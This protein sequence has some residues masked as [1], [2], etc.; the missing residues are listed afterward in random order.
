MKPDDKYKVIHFSWKD[1]F[2]DE[3]PIDVNEGL[4]GTRYFT[5]AYNLRL[6]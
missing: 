4:S 2:T 5:T 3:Q 6:F 1:F